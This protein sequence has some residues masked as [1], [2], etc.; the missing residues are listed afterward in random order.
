MS[1]QSDNSL[2]DVN[3]ICTVL[4]PK[5]ASSSSPVI[6]KG[7]PSVTEPWLISAKRRTVN[8]LMHRRGPGTADNLQRVYDGPAS[9]HINIF[10]KLK[11]N[12]A[13]MKH[14]IF[15]GRLKW[16]TVRGHYTQCLESVN[17]VYHEMF[18]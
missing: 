2:T 16:Y 4:W 7:A 1:Q 15:S 3:V 10:L 18:C 11:S 8:S 13:Y 14:F 6:D 5:T 17:N 9:A 12:R